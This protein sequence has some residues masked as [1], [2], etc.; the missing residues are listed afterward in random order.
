MK[1]VALLKN[2]FSKKNILILLLLLLLIIVFNLFTAYMDKKYADETI[3]EL[4][5]EYGS[6]EKIPSDEYND[7]VT[8]YKMNDFILFCGGIG[9][10]SFY[11]EMLLMSMQNGA[12]RKSFLKAF[13]ILMLSYGVIFS[14]VTSVFN[15]IGNR[16]FE[17]STFYTT[18][19]FIYNAIHNTSGFHYLA[20]FIEMSCLLIF[21]SLLSSTI[22]MV[23]K[24]LGVAK[25][26]ICTI[27]IVAIILITTLMPLFYGYKIISLIL[28]G[29][30]LALLI[31]LFIVMSLKSTLENF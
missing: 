2:Y 15:V 12:S 31:V 6:I 11:S 9:M 28:C 20:G 27:P 26:I 17:C 21:G 10:Y 4:V 8:N 22:M 25:F 16:I 13:I 30:Y 5:S 19:D 18:Y 1:T 24:K 29:V 23:G 3:E 14:A 7:A